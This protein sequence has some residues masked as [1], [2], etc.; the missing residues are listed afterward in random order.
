MAPASGC[1][2]ACR[3]GALWAGTGVLPRD[4]KPTPVWVRR[5]GAQ[6]GAEP[7]DSPRQRRRHAEMERGRAG[8]APHADRSRA[9]AASTCRVRPSRSS[10]SGSPKE[11]DEG[12]AGSW[13]AACC[14]AL[15]GCSAPGCRHA[16]RRRQQIASG[17]W[18]AQPPSSLIRGCLESGAAPICMVDLLCACM[19]APG[20]CGCAPA[21]QPVGGAR[22]EP[23]ARTCRPSMF[24]SSCTR[25]SLPGCTCLGPAC[26]PASWP[27]DEACGLSCR[28]CCGGCCCGNS[29]CSGCCSC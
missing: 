28:G 20:L 16:R 3:W 23:A 26:P 15:P 13:A 18:H 11:A 4:C 6:L 19:R 25:C 29:T 7:P 21:R 2:R 5:T 14:A 12:A 27:C 9:G 10:V 8:R 24:H 1:C 17:C 22:L